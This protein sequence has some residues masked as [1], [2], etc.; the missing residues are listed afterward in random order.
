MAFN[1]HVIPHPDIMPPALDVTSNTAAVLCTPTITAAKDSP[2]KE[3]PVKESS[4]GSCAQLQ[5]Q[6]NSDE[7]VRQGE[8]LRGVSMNATDTGA[9]Q[10]RDGFHPGR[11]ILLTWALGT[12]ENLCDSGSSQLSL[13][14]RATRPCVAPG[15]SL[16]RDIQ[17]QSQTETIDCKRPGSRK[18]IGVLRSVSRSLIEA[19]RCFTRLCINHTSGATTGVFNRL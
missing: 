15:L 1:P 5:A 10:R 9:G 19:V 13:P 16:S 2:A 3:P 14:N 6:D 12:Q 7:H 8:E 11:A 18:E 17:T 4:N